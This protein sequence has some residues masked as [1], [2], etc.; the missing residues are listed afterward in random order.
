MIGEVPFKKMEDF[1][2]QV[3]WCTLAILAYQGQGRED[4][5]KFEAS[6]VYVSSRPALWDYYI[7]Y[8]HISCFRKRMLWRR[9]VIMVAQH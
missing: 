7:G 6:L 2:N 4:H 1:W 8:I 9:T 3:W 5:H